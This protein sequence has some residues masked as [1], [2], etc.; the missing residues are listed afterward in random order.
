MLETLDGTFTTSK[1]V[2]VN[3]DH[4]WRNPEE[5]NARFCR[6]HGRAV[7]E[8]LY[9]LD[10]TNYPETIDKAAQYGCTSDFLAAYQRAVHVLKADLVLFVHSY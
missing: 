6:E 8:G 4:F 3:C 10:G 1:L 5:V 2:E 7:G 9:L